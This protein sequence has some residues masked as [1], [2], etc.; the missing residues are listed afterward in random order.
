MTVDQ[1]RTVRRAQPFR[2]FALHLTD[3]RQFRIEHPEF[4][5]QS[6]SGRTVVI[7]STDDSFEIIDLL[8][9]TSIEVANGKPQEHAG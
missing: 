5:L 3:G 7:E 6:R 9:V 8:L 1:L 2:P 4:L